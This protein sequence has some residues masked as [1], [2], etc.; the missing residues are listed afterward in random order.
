MRVFLNS[1][2]GLCLATVVGVTLYLSLFAAPPKTE[3]VK[4]LAAYIPAE[5]EGW[6]VEDKPLGETEALQER[7]LDVLQTDDYVYRSY[8]KGRLNFEVYVAYWEPGKMPIRLVNTHKPDRCWTYTGWT[9]EEVE[10]NVVYKV[11]EQNLKPAEYRSFVK[12]GNEQQTFFWHLVGERVHS[13]GGFRPNPPVTYMFNE[14]MLYGLKPPA[15]QYFIRVNTM[16]DFET[17][18][19]EPGFQKVLEQLGDSVLF[20][21]DQEAQPDA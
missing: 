20:D 19:K 11:G 15:E 10:S 4:P 16:D 1:L 14:L 7:T 2:L 9:C 18:W 6:V 21:A 8:T 12:E 5:M 3:K 17:L 13:Y